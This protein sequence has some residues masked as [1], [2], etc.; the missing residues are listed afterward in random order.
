MKKEFTITDGTIIQPLA[1]A[2]PSLGVFRERYKLLVPADVEK[3]P[4][5]LFIMGGETAL[6]DRQLIRAFQAYGKRNDMVLLCGEHRGYGMSIGG[7][8]QSCPA[9]VSVREALADFHAIRLTLSEQFT[10][11]WIACGR[12]YGGSLALDYAYTYPQDVSA[13]LCSSGVVDWNALLPEYDIA[14]RE[15]LGPELYGRLCDHIDRLSPA[16]PFTEYWYDRELLYAFVT[17]LCQYRE[18]RGLLPVVAALAKLPARQFVGALKQADRLFA[19][20][21]AALYANSNRT[22]SLSNDEAL[23]CDYGWHVWRYQQAFGLG[24]FWAPSEARSIYRRSTDDWQ[25]ECC[26]LF[27]KRAPVFD[28]GTDWNVR[29]L[30]PK[31]RMPLIYVRG[32]RDPWRRVGLSDDYP[33]ENGKVITIPDG[34]HCPDTYP[35]TGPAIIQ[36]LLTYLKEER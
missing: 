16:E 14:V 34:F 26:A 11:E 24:T 2:N 18:Y 36:E 28:E 3:R 8:D 25:N 9:Y 12:S 13:V 10:G 1:H 19:K 31:L 17:G 21:S 20:G 15:N 35:D 32:G 33:L 7:D 6:A 29:D 5:V 30:V 22:T 27:G 4:R 23:S